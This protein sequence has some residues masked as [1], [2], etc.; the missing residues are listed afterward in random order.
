[1][2]ATADRIVNVTD[3]DE[4]VRAVVRA[5]VALAADGVPLDRIGVFYP[6]PRPYVR[7]IE[8]HVLAAGLPANGPSIDRLADSV[9]GRVLRAALVLPDERWRRDR[10]MAL[11]ADAPLAVLG[12][13]CPP[14]GVG[15]RLAMPV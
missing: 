5:I 12:R 14:G 11:V 1:M 15:T 7:I 6:Q 9:A 10:V 3:A 13:S 2:P 4:E 8:Q